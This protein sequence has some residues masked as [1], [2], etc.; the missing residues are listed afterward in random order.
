MRNY[1]RKI[2]PGVVT[3]HSK[4]LQERQ[5]ILS[6]MN[7]DNF[8]AD[9]N[10]RKGWVPA[11]KCLLTFS[12]EFLEFSSKFSVISW[13]VCCFSVSQMFA[14][15]TKP[16]SLFVT[17]S[18]RNT[19]SSKPAIFAVYYANIVKDAITQFCNVNILQENTV[20]P[21]LV[22]SKSKGKQLGQ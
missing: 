20:M 22:V 8:L 1:T 15:L 11:S 7:M 9:V 17:A 19:K 21:Y 12:S 14:F 3:E 18:K 5:A 13:T 16:S 2:C 10:Q 6:L 4:K